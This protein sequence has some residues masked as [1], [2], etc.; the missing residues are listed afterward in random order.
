MI[1]SFNSDEDFLLWIANRLVYR[2]KE[3][4]TIIDRVKFIIEKNKIIR[5]V[6]DNNNIS[7]TRAITETIKY[8]DLVKEKNQVEIKSLSSKFK[9]IK[10][11]NNIIDLENIDMD[12]VLKGVSKK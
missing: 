12:Y 6:L 7:M 9:D 1:N 4:S 8:L 10:I 5:N 3:N 2:Y 11:D